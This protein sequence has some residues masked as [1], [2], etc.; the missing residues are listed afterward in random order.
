[1]DGQTARMADNEPVH[2]R[3]AT[4]GGRLVEVIGWLVIAAGVGL[5]IVQIV[6]GSLSLAGIVLALFVVV[7]GAAVTSIGRSISRSREH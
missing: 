6:Q 5:V 2:P 3:G 1:M 4:L 7:A